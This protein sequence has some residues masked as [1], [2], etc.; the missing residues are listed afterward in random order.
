M[1]KH[2]IHCLACPGGKCLGHEIVEIDPKWSAEFD[3][4]TLGRSVRRKSDPREDQSEA[5]TRYLREHIAS[6]HEQDFLRVY[7]R[8]RTGQ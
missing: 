6:G 4:R 7:R 2:F 5:L 3:G 1:Q 8:E